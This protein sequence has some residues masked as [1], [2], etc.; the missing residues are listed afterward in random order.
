M[1]EK[2][3]KE[4]FWGHGLLPFLYWSAIAALCAWAVHTF[5]AQH[6]RD[7]VSWLFTNVL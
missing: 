7:G 5:L 2:K 4:P 6:I 3:T 1:E